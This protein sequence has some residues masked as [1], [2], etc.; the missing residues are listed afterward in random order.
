[1][2][3]ITDLRFS[4]RDFVKSAVA[5][6]SLIPM[7]GSPVLAST[8][9]KGGHFRLGL[10]HGNTTDNYDPAQWNNG[11]S[12]CF[13]FAREAM[14]TEIAPDNSL[15]PSLAE[16][17]EP[18]SDAKMWSFNLVK[19][20]TFSDGRDVTA[21]DVIASFNHHRGEE[22]KS[23]AKPIV[24]P[25][26]EMKADGK[27]RIIFTL[28]SGNADFPFVLS[29]YHLVIRPAKDGKID[30]EANIGAGG[31]VVKAYEPGVRAEIER[32]ND[33]WKSDRAFFDSAE[34]LTILD[35]T[36]RM[37]ALLSNSVEAIDSVDLATVELLKRNPGI[38][39]LSVTGTQHFTFAMDTRAEPF[40]DNNVRLAL[41]YGIK[42]QEL[43][44]KILYG[45]GSVGNDHPIGQS[46]RYY[47]SELE[48]REY[49]ADKAKY[50]L[51]Q[52]G[53]ESIEVS[54][55]AADAAFQGA[56]DAAQLFE[57]SAAAAGIKINIVREAND[58]YWSNVWMKKPFS[59]VYWGGRPTEDWMFSTAYSSG[60]AW[61][62]T[63]WEN[64]RFNELLG[65]AR[66][67]L[68][69]AKRRQMYVELQS[70][71][72][73]DGGAIIPMFA[74][75]VGAHTKKIAHGEKIAANWAMDG[76]RCIERWWYA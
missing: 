69:E 6:A 13:A 8:P 73:D 33:Y 44:D 42:R 57:A 25:I 72:R 22:S 74:S 15:A 49:D 28:E 10:K 76:W 56:V 2:K 26:K 59:A 75:Y 48:Q 65:Q 19:G 71:V 5:T 7:V 58:G 23:A 67:E 36:A 14:L 47:A 51:K 9:K 16:S 17:W 66:S 38:E 18:S 35:P 30:P 68:D 39:V 55:S 54:L 52:A 40:K 21:E 3:R 61:N 63:F 41:K 53:L 45:Y 4:R 32:R 20:A 12:Q 34:I 29:D 31:Y 11:Y 60:A 64:A 24:S 37:N 27:N 43:I 50:H 62:D 46:N 70:I 1:M